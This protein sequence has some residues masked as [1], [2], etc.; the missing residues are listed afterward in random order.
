MKKLILT[1]GAALFALSLGFAGTVNA[2]GFTPEQKKKCTDAGRTVMTSQEVKKRGLE[3]MLTEDSKKLLEHSD[4][5]H[6]L[7]L[8]SVPDSGATPATDTTAKA[9]ADAKAPAATNDKLATDL[10]RD[11]DFAAWKANCTGPNYEFYTRAE[12][13][14]QHPDVLAN[15]PAEVQDDL[16]FCRKKGGATAWN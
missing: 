8:S 14:A 16:Y 6:C 4:A 1:V 9:P 7:D 5:E 3:Y 11:K 13:Q 10:A 2:G 15:A 12:M